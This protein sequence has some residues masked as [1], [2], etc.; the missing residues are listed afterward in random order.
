MNFWLILRRFW[1]LNLFCCCFDR[2]WN[3]N[4]YRRL[5]N[6]EL[7]WRIAPYRSLLK[8]TGR[9]WSFRFLWFR[10]QMFGVVRQTNFILMF[11]LI[12]F[13]FGWG[14]AILFGFSGKYDTFVVLV[15]CALNLLCTRRPKVWNHHLIR[16]RLLKRCI[17]DI[18]RRENLFW[19]FE[20]IILTS[21]CIWD[22][23]FRFCKVWNCYQRFHSWVSGLT[24]ALFLLLRLE[25]D[26]PVE[27]RLKESLVQPLRLWGFCVIWNVVLL[28]LFPVKCHLRLL[29]GKILL[30]G[31]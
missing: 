6:R 22:E 9:V 15:L 26:F 3:L 11:L 10:F 13:L 16:K 19:E 25:K 28:R 12:L 20:Q 30:N 8:S 14:W 23:N 5:V 7:Y 21:C 27:L 17:H 24:T 2:L 1:L 18:L 31:L 29:I 4:F